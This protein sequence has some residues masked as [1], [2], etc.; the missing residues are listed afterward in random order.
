MR[1]LALETSG[2]SGSV[3]ALADGRL[4]VEVALP[5]D[6]RSARTLAPAVQSALA[7]AAWKPRD[8]ELVAVTAGPGSFTGL[9]VG[10]A[11]AK[12]LAYAVGAEVLG[13]DTLEAIVRRAPV[14][15]GV[16][17]AVV[18]AER[19]Q[20]FAARFL[21]GRHDG[22]RRA[23]GDAIVDNDAWLAALRAGE[24]VTGPGL[25]R[26]A[27]RLPEGVVQLPR[28]LWYP[29]AHSVG[30]LAA[31]EFAAGRRDDLWTFAPRYLRRSA[32]EEKLAAG[33]N[34]HQSGA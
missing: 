14:H 26:L 11:T 34:R 8:V 16:L 25:E 20:V 13:V 15:P 2:T 10:V 33:E 19:E 23:D 21:P 30:L 5:G 28:S 3:A 1:I 31:D 24:H 17:W 29:T 4:L 9:R 6:R 32:A 18:N 27:T 22:W 12:A 7:R